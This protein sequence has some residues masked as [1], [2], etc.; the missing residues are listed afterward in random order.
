MS[1]HLTT[2]FAI[3]WAKGIS[4]RT[5]GT[6]GAP[7]ILTIHGEDTEGQHNEAEITIYTDNPALTEG[8]VAAINGVHRAVKTETMEDA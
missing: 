2:C 1:L 3:H 5:I 4:A 7:L 8:L 6:S